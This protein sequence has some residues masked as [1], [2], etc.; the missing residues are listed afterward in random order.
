MKSDDDAVEGVIII[1]CQTAMN[2]WAKGK[3][4]FR[5]QKEKR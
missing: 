3:Y 2:C 1:R 5:K 4:L